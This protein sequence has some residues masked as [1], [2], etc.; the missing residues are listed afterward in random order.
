MA[1]WNLGVFM[2][3]RAPDEPTA[4]FWEIVIHTG[5]IALPAFYYHFVLIF[6]ESTTRHRTSLV[7]AYTLAIVFNIINVSGSPLFMSG[8]KSTYWGWAP[9]TGPLYTPF[10]IYFNFF[11][12]YGLLHLIRVYKD[13]ESSFRRNRATLILLGTGVSL[14]GGVIDFARFILTRSHRADLVYP[15]GIPA[16]MIFALML[17]TSIVR[18]RLFDV[19]VLVKKGAIY[20]LLWGADRHPGHGGVV[21]GLGSGQPA[22]GHPAARLP[23]DDAGEPDRPAA[24]GAHRAPDVQPAPGLLRD[25]AGPQQADGLDPRFRPP[26]GDARARPRARGPADPLRPDDLRPA[27]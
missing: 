1:V 5:V 11:L 19:N 26:H 13:V 21:R 27:A 18:Y 7:V 14:I 8:V 6:L 9:A 16:N 24:R 23:L 20:L 4:V 25:L 2:L 22:L 3:R 17:G 10:F 15:M 12:I